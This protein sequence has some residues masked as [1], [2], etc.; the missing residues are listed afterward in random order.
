MDPERVAAEPG[1]SGPAGVSQGAKRL[2]DAYVALDRDQ[3]FAAVAA[4]GLL[5]AMFLPWY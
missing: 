1:G 2:R 3:R 4:I 5:V